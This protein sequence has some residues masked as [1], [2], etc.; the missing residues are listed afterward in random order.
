MIQ[1][2]S[3]FQQLFDTIDICHI[4]ETVFLSRG[5]LLFIYSIGVSLQFQHY[6]QMK[7]THAFL[8]KKELH[9]NFYMIAGK[10]R[11]RAFDP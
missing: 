3:Y 6:S 5:E 2:E 8:T 1:I 9:L 4:M 11:G 10:N 7:I